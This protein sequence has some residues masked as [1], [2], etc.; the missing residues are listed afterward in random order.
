MLHHFDKLIFEGS[1]LV[2]DILLGYSYVAEL[3]L[4]NLRPVSI[5]LAVFYKKSLHSFLLVF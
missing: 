4:P 2:N 5:L 1:V 3:V